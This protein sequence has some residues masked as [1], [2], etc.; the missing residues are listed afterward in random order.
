M[1]E[2]RWRVL[3]VTLAVA[4][5]LC[6]AA[7]L[8]IRPTAA[9]PEPAWVDPQLE[10]A[11]AAQGEVNLVAHFRGEPDLSGAY[12]M[13][14]DD[15]GDF[16]VKA[17][18]ENAERSQGRVTVFL[19]ARGIP[20]QSSFADNALYIP[21]AGKG[22]LQE[23]LAFPE[24]AR[25][26]LE[27]VYSIPDLLPEEGDASLQAVEWGVGK[28][29]AD[30]V[31]ALGYK[32]QGLVVANIDTGVRYTH[33]ALRNQYRGN[34]GNGTFTHSYSWYDPTGTYP[35]APGDNNGHGTHTMGTMV[36]DDGGGNQIGVAP[37]A[38]WIACKGCS[39]SSCAASTL[40]AC[41]NWMLAPGGDT[42]KRPQVVN[43]SWGGCSFTDYYRPAINA[44]RASGI[45]PVFSAGNTSNCTYGSAFC[46]SIGNPAT[47]KEVTA[48]G[49]TTSSDSIASFSL[50]GPSVDPT[51]AGEIKPE[52]SA[53]GSSIRS[54][55][56]TSDNSY[57]LYSG[58]SMAAPHT[59]GALAVIWSACPALVGNFDATEQLL[60]TTAAKFALATNCGGEGAG[61]IPNNAFGYGRIDVLAAV[62]AC[63]TSG[64]TP[65][66][67]PPTPTFTPAPPTPTF[68]ATA[69]RVPPTA[70]PVPAAIHIGDLDSSAVWSG[71]NKWS[72]TITIL[73]HDA[74]HNPVSGVTV[75]GR[76]S[77]AAKGTV[78]CVTSS[79]GACNVVK[80]NL[81]SKATSLT[82][83]V[84]NLTKVGVTYSAVDNHDVDLGTDGT[85]ITVNRP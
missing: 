11:L 22:L 42:A 38:T 56:N 47:Y 1:V 41:F 19:K 72:A 36:G 68:T 2:K 76:W 52:V 35:S 20:F 5:V 24:A 40:S 61:N 74:Q 23:L 3:F 21:R 33:A 55:V 67:A 30:D 54:S 44:L 16:V 31:W 81:S 14:W 80:G 6:V 65:T 75:T 83:T 46:G 49:A 37:G 71:A 64:P 17:L 43:N 7:A 26:E 45:H 4:F 9:A 27:P 60:K 39:S 79:S 8:Q 13:S 51:G 34:N 28:I 50:W 62:N 32:G 25:F 57:A 70:T 53:P 18:R 73:V 66:P 78:T 15:R 84:T 12:T 77:G 48:V 63:R 82:F 58:T 59:S 85:S 69:T 29:N 10:A